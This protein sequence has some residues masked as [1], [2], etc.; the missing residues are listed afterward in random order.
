[1]PKLIKFEAGVPAWVED[2]FLDVADEDLTPGQGA[3]ILSLARFQA[4]GAD[5]LASGREVGVK[6]QAGELVEEIAGALPKL[7]LVALDFP[8][9]RDGRQYTE[10]A[11]LRGR[12]RYGGEI[13]A[14]GAFTVE[15][16]H[17]L[18]RCG[19]DA[20]APQDGSTLELWAGAAHRY[21]KVYQTGADGREPIFAERLRAAE[22]A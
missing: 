13:R 12:Y 17:F 6:L 8:K 10:A 18:L 15:Q 11:L 2:A 21:R 3:V 19:F 20:F 16:G 9:V 14:V 5:L 22:H 1:M 7:A 4:E